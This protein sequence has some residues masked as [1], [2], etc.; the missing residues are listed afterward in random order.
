[1]CTLPSR[2]LRTHSHAWRLR[3][4]RAVLGAHLD[5]AVVAPRGLDHL[6][7]LVDR[8]AQRLLAVHV[9]AGLA[10]HDRDRGVPVVGRGDQHRVDVLAVQDAAEV[11]VDVAL[12]DPLLRGGRVLLVHVAHRGDAC[13]GVVVD[14]QQAHAASAAADQR[15]HHPLAGRR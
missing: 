9:L 14:A 11:L 15:R 5:D 4:D 2:P 6:P 1:M 13:S 12:P 10:G 7:A 8:A 3:A